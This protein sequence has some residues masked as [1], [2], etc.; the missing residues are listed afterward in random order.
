MRIIIVRSLFLNVNLRT[1]HK[2]DF[3]PA[4]SP[5]ETDQATAI[6]TVKLL[7]MLSRSRSWRKVAVPPHF[8]TYEMMLSV[9]E[10]MMLSIFAALAAYSYRRFGRKPIRL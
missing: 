8:S 10:Q 2:G 1:S 5:Q 4:I 7:P 3:L 9:A 6:A